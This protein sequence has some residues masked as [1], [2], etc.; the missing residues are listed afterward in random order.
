VDT[1]STEE[2]REGEIEVECGAADGG[3]GVGAGGDG[4]QMA[5]GRV[6]YLAKL[7]ERER[8]REAEVR[9]WLPGTRKPA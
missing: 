4:G 1:V 2:E 3:E 8:L 5:P 9:S 7:R 6:G